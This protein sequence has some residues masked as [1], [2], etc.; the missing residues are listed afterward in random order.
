M[1]ARPAG[2]IGDIQALR[3]VAIALVLAYHLSLTATLWAKAPQKLCMPFFLGVPLF[4]IISGYVVT[5]SLRKDDFNGLKFLVKRVFRLVPALLVFLG[6][7]YAAIAYAR[8]T[9]PP[10]HPEWS[11]FAPSDADFFRQARGVLG[12]YF[13]TL[14]PP[15]SYHFGAM[16]SLSVEDQFYAGIA[17]VCLAGA[18][19]RRLTRVPAR[20]LVLAACA[21]FTLSFAWLRWRAFRG[22]YPVHSP[23]LCYLLAYRFDFLPLGVLLAMYEQARPGRVRARSAETGPFSAG[24]LLLI[25]LALVAVSESVYSAGPKRIL[26]GVAMPL[27]ALAF[28]RLVLLAGNDCAFPRSRGPAYRALVYLGDRSYTL[29]LLHFPVFAV[30]WLVMARHA[31]WFFAKPYRFEL[32]QLLAA[33]VILAVLV[34]VVYRG[35][36]LPLTRYGKRLVEGRP[37]AP[38]AAGPTPP[39]PRRAAWPLRLVARLLA[40][41]AKS[42]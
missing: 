33:A 29:Y 28:A 32:G 38:H 42:R 11:A 25:P 17:L 23:L 27:A 40:G 5:L 13:L 20:W 31:P 1:E 37:P 8:A 4:F 6:I 16:W 24:F 34:E 10:G 14:D 9:L 18:V 7:S 22:H 30:I 12:G 26:D 3:G 39:A 15:F 21:A 35:V 19:L 36:E 41:A 2:K